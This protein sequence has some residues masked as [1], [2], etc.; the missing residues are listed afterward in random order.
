MT[1]AEQGII[2]GLKPI[3]GW[4]YPQ[5]FAGTFSIVL[6]MH[7]PEGHYPNHGEKLVAAVILFRR[8]QG[9]PAGEP[10]RDVAEF[11]RRASPQNDYYRGK[12]PD[13]IGKP[14]VRSI[15]PLIQDIREWIEATILQKPDMVGIG[16]ASD[17]AQ[18]CIKCQQNVRWRIDCAPCNEEVEQRG[19]MLRAIPIFDYD[20]ALL[21]CRLHK[22]AL[23]AAVFLDRDFLPA[24]SESAP[25]PCWIPAKT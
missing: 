7:A 5:P 10:E 15:T 11:I 20:P 8:M 23:Q 22:M 3:G 1:L 19:L 6:P 2:T 16:D 4:R 21:A 14:R 12:V 24:R 18:I 13:S 9:I 17:R 25:E